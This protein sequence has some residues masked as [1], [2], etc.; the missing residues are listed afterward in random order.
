MSGTRTVLGRRR[1]RTVETL[2][3]AATVI[4]V[5]A[6]VMTATAGC[7]A[8]GG[9]DTAPTDAG[10]A[11][12]LERSTVHVG[13]LPIVDTA[14]VQHAQA[15][16]YFAAEGL[17]VDLV[18]VQGG[19]VAVPQLVAGD[20]DLTWSS[21]NTVIQAQQADVGDLQVLP[22]S[23]YSAAANTFVMMVNSDSSIRTAQDLPGKRIAI[24]TFGSIARLVAN[25]A[26]ETNGVD[27]DRVTYVEIPFPDMIAALGNHQVDAIVVVEPQLTQ[28]AAQLGAIT[29]LDVASGPTADLP[30]AGLVTTTEFARKNPDTLAAFN[31]AIT[32]AQADMTDRSVVLNTLPTYTKITPDAAPLM[33]V[34]A[35]PTTVT[36]IDLQRIADLMQHFGVLR[37]RFDVTPLFPTP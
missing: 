2:R 6:V 12:L 31:R 33:Q 19:A 9:S 15:A 35:W 18:T 37:D 4:M 23:G 10:P 28:A 8:L 26:M 36:S 11:G 1:R 22:G 32:R 20:L 21:W 17:G 13:V 3:T 14:A 34:G 27:P 5:V 29:V 7:G 16:G 30:E 24:N 25:S